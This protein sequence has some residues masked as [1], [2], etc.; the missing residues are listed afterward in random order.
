LLSALHLKRVPLLR[1][2]P[3]RTQQLSEA[4]A[5]GFRLIGYAGNSAPDHVDQLHS[6][7]EY[8]EWLK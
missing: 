2:G 3:M 1:W 5:G 6:L 7:A 4:R 8:L